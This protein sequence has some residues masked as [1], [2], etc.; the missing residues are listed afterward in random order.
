VIQDSARHSKNIFSKVQLILDL[1]FGLQLQ[2]LPSKAWLDQETAAAAAESKKGKKT[3]S[4]AQEGD[5]ELEEARRA[6]AGKRK[7]SIRPLR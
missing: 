2:E 3:G 1:R 4:A 7:M 5:D 6:V